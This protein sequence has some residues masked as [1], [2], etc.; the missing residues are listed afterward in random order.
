MV[1]SPL[2]YLMTRYPRCVTPGASITLVRS[3]SMGAAPKWSNNRTPFPST[4]RHVD[5]DLVH[6]S[7]VEAL[8]QDTGGA[9]DDILFAGGLLC[10]MNGAFHPIGDKGERRSFVDPFL[11]D[12]MGDDKSRRPRGMAAPGP[13]DI[14]GSPSP[15]PRPV[16]CERLLKDFGA[17]RRDL[18]H[19]VA[20]RDRNLC[21][22]AEVPLKERVT[23]IPHTIVGAVV[24]AGNE[25]VQR[26][27]HIENNF[28]HLYAP[29]MR[30]F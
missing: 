21:V 7:Q 6:Q 19:H 12:G 11:W 29:F 16:S 17:L 18:E 1:M 20:I 8:L 9:H 2:A 26:N 23:T 14:K 25:A 4:R 22:A 27:G 5:M 30:L 13:G 10:L 3:S 28:S 15:Y 24:R